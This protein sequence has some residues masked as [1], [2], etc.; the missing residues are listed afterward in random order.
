M[1]KV[2]IIIKN[3]CTKLKACYDKPIFQERS[4]L[5]EKV[6]LTTMII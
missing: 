5:A 6:V 1:L 4:S 3:N 2:S